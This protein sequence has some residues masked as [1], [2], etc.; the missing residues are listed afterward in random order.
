MIRRF[1][2]K[3]LNTNLKHFAYEKKL[4]KLKK[5]NTGIVINYK[6]LFYAL[7]HMIFNANETAN[8][9]GNDCI[10]KFVKC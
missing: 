9:C 10:K 3:N 2:Y 6:T 5:T 4:S 8:V 7:Q 1:S